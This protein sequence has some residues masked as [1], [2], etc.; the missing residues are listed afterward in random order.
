MCGIIWV[1]QFDKVE[2]FVYCILVDVE[3]EYEWLLGWQCQMLVCI[4]VL[5]WVIDVVVGDFGLLVVCK[6][7]CEVWILMQGVYCELMLMLN[8]IIFQVCWLVI[9][10][11]DVSGKLQIV[12]IFNGMLV[13]IWWLVVILENYQWFDGS[14]RVLDVLVLF[15][16]V[17]V[18]ELVVQW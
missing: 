15:V 8:C 2:G 6:F 18:L 7:D 3:Y 9:C 17:E 13:I 1:Y 5:Y 10:Y 12:V 14:V 4:E 16:G 11:W